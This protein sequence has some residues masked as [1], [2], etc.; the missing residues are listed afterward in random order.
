MTE[1]GDNHS[2]LANKRETDTRENLPDETD[3][4]ENLPD[5]TDIR[6]RA[7]Q[8]KQISEREPTR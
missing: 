7:Y 6:E 2:K 8:M 4:R 3:I 1:R 5:K